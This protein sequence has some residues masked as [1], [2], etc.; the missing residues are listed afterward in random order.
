MEHLNTTNGALPQTEKDK[1]EERIMAYFDGSLDKASSSKLL[2]DV[3]TNVESR[4][5]FHSHEVLNRVIAAARVP[6]EA[7]ME[8]K[9]GIVERIPGLVAFIPG[10]LGGAHAIP[11]LTQSANPI[12][13]F[14]SKIP[15][16][17][18]ISV[19]TSAVVLTT[20]GV[21]VKNKLD[22]NAA[23]EAKSRAAVVRQ[24]EAP[25]TSVAP[26]APLATSNATT[27][28]PSATAKATTS[29][30]NLSD[31][32]DRTD[33]TIRI[34]KTNTPLANR[35]AEPVAATPS[36]LPVKAIPAAS[37][38]QPP[39]P[40]EDNAPALRTVAPTSIPTAMA[41]FPGSRPSV[42]SR[43]P[44]EFG[45]GIMVRPF[46]SVGIK[47]SLVSVSGE[48]SEK[49]DR[50]NPQSSPFDIRGGLDFLLSDSWAIRAQGGWSSFA[51]QVMRSGQDLSYSLPAY[52]QYST[53]NAMWAGWATVGAAYSFDIGEHPFTASAGGGLALLTHSAPMLD[54]GL[55]TEF[56]LSSQFSLR[57]SLIYQAVWTKL[58]DQ[59]S[60][61]P[62]GSAIFFD[63]TLPPLSVSSTIGL[64]VGLI[65]RF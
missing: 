35:A 31:L 19:G 26:Y 60:G 46:F 50:S 20:A 23:S 30:S 7:P 51:E 32:A 37:Q 34:A 62:Q 5:L 63:R 41:H 45:E 49:L 24:Y 47:Q 18:A 14:L 1:L 9:R 13:A 12:L 22:D 61:V 2:A 29:K 15:L 53:V 4:A 48:V 42:L 59:R 52:I 39:A 64:N 27:V 16:S 40:P 36:A 11:V 57:P 21:I 33:R 43:M 6:L 10:L 17:T 25:Q 28:A 54:L 55:S 58:E 8:V 3:S 38:V 65:F 56:D 44:V